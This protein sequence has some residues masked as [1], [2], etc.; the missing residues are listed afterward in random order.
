MKVLKI[1][2]TVVL[3]WLLLIILI[4]LGV[5]LTLQSTLLN[6]DFA[7]GHAARL[8]L[9]AL[10]G[11]LITEY[12]DSQPA[13]QED[14]IK[15]L[16]QRIVQEEEPWLK[17][18]MDGAIH[19][20]Y[21]F[22]LGATDSLLITV[23][24]L[25]LKQ[26]LKDRLWQAIADDPA[27]WLPL[28][29]DELNAYIDG[30]FTTLVEGFRQYLPPDLAALPVEELKPRLHDY[31]LE[32]E[33][34]LARPD[35]P[36]PADNLL[37][38]VARP[39]FNDFYDEMAIDIPDEIIVDSADIPADVMPDLLLAQRYIHYFR[40]GF[41][42][43][44]ALAVVLAGCILLINRSVR[45]ACLALGI[46]LVAAGAL[47]SAGVTLAGNALPPDLLAAAPASLGVWVDGLYRDTLSVARIYSII[48]LA[49]GVILL[50]VSIFYRS[51]TSAD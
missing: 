44:I 51:K 12:T 24:L 17:E 48:V 40:T 42:L 18:Q 31:L 28:F 16:A 19:A 30:D 49:V 4:F 23:P 45:G 9:S 10:T 5:A 29:Q 37:L 11:D 3:G 34:Q 7:A 8:D 21:D 1:L 47:E 26:D 50:A 41:F 15:K 35:G 32:L 6:A 43:M 14:L 27:A 39:Y 2:G 38:A 36:P 22:F 13:A 20:G 25:E 46:V 33:A